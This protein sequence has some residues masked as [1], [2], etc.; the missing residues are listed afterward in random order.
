LTILNLTMANEAAHKDFI[1]ALQKDTRGAVDKLVGAV[2]NIFLGKPIVEQ[3]FTSLH[4]RATDLLLSAQD[5]SNY[6]ETDRDMISLELVEI[7]SVIDGFDKIVSGA[8]KRDPD[9][10]LT[11]IPDDIV[12]TQKGNKTFIE[13]IGG[14]K[15]VMGDNKTIPLK[16]AMELA[17][18]AEQAEARVEDG[19]EPQWLEGEAKDKQIWESISLKDKGTLRGVRRIISVVGLDPDSIATGVLGKKEYIYIDPN[20]GKEWQ[21][22]KGDRLTDVKH[23][24]LKNK[25]VILPTGEEFVPKPGDSP[26]QLY[27]GKVPDDWGEPAKEFK[28]FVTQSGGK[29]VI[30]TKTAEMND[31][32]VL[33]TA[34][35]QRVEAKVQEMVKPVLPEDA[36]LG[37]R[38]ISLKDLLIKLTGERMGLLADAYMTEINRREGWLGFEPVGDTRR[39]VIQGFDQS[40][41]MFNDALNRAGLYDKWRAISTLTEMNDR[42]QMLFDAVNRKDIQK[43]IEGGILSRLASAENI[44]TWIRDI[45]GLA[46]VLQWKE[47]GGL[48]NPRTS[49]PLAY[50]AV[51]YQPSTATALTDRLNDGKITKIVRRNGDSLS[52]PAMY[53]YQ[54]DE[55][56]I[57]VIE[58]DADGAKSMAL[59][60]VMKEKARYYG[61]DDY[62]VDLAFGFSRFMFTGLDRGYSYHKAQA[63]DDYKVIADKIG[64]AT[65][66]FEDYAHLSPEDK[67]D[68]ETLLQQISIAQTGVKS[69]FEAVLGLRDQNPQNRD[70]WYREAWGDRA[71][72]YGEPKKWFRDRISW[73]SDENIDWNQEAAR[74]DVY[75]WM[76]EFFSTLGAGMMDK[77]GKFAGRET[78]FNPKNRHHR[79]AIIKHLRTSEKAGDLLVGVGFDMDELTPQRLAELIDQIFPAGKLPKNPRGNQV[80]FLSELTRFNDIMGYEGGLNATA[81]D[82][83]LVAD[84]FKDAVRLEKV[85]ENP[86]FFDNLLSFTTDDGWTPN[87]ELLATIKGFAGKINDGSYNKFIYYQLYWYSTYLVLAENFVHLRLGKKETS[88]KDLQDK[89]LG[90]WQDQSTRDVRG[91]RPAFAFHLANEVQEEFVLEK[92]K[93]KE[94]GHVALEK[95]HDEERFWN[96]A[97]LFYQDPE[98]DPAEHEKAVKE[99]CRQRMLKLH[100]EIDKVYMELLRRKQIPLS[101]VRELIDPDGNTQMFRYAVMTEDGRLVGPGEDNGRD[102]QEYLQAYDRA[103]RGLNLQASELEHVS[104]LNDLDWASTWGDKEEKK[105]LLQDAQG[106]YKFE[107]KDV[108][109]GIM[110]NDLEI[111]QQLLTWYNQLKNLPE[112][113]WIKRDEQGHFDGRDIPQI[114]VGFAREYLDYVPKDADGNPMLDNTGQEI[115]LAVDLRADT[116]EAEAIRGFFRH[117]LY[118]NDRGE[119]NAL[120]QEQFN[121]GFQTL[122]GLMFG[123][124]VQGRGIPEDRSRGPRGIMPLRCYLYDEFYKKLLRDGDK[125]EVARG[126][127]G[128]YDNLMQERRGVG[129][130]TWAEFFEANGVG[131]LAKKESILER[132]ASLISRDKI[133][134]TSYDQFGEQIQASLGFTIRPDARNFSMKAQ[135]SQALEARI[136]AGVLNEPAATW[137]EV[138]ETLSP[139][140]LLST[141]EISSHIAENYGLKILGWRHRLAYWFGS[142]KIGQPFKGAINRWI[143]S[144]VSPNQ[145][146]VILQNKLP[147]P[148]Q[149]RRWIFKTYG[150]DIG[151][152]PDRAAVLDA[153]DQIVP[154]RWQDQ[155]PEVNTFV[156]TLGDASR[157]FS[158]LGALKSAFGQRWLDETIFT[159]PNRREAQVNIDNLYHGIVLATADKYLGVVTKDRITAQLSR[160]FFELR[161]TAGQMSMTIKEKVEMYKRLRSYIPFGQYSW[162]LLEIASRQL[163]GFARRTGDTLTD[164]MLGL[165]YSPAPGLSLITTL[166]SKAI[167]SIHGSVFD[168][169]VKTKVDATWGGLIPAGVAAYYAFGLVAFWGLTTGWATIPGAALVI[170]AYSG[171]G[172][173]G[174]WYMSKINNWMERKKWIEHHPAYVYLVERGILR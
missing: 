55:G 103:Q 4:S 14:E 20:T 22:E 13:A 48:V 117:W 170:G 168:T 73:A 114:L 43:G 151:N 173:V 6:G 12:I 41:E 2:K 84:E 9:N 93:R 102:S 23:K 104:R 28:F 166:L 3:A 116:E 106:M 53:T 140:Q 71:P 142:K 162:Q 172:W 85:L 124:D 65:D 122:I 21:P 143:N 80:N 133:F 82:F 169:F 119:Y 121:K 44:I 36:S 58:K 7:K 19:E 148:R 57:F 10:P 81:D 50:S 38:R 126:Y 29:Q 92:I 79:Q 88:V 155:N 39:M 135:V 78:P 89:L 75:R 31:R 109:Y 144:R 76:G 18:K 147:L 52:G 42:F 45:P 95:M 157:G 139:A 165:E 146:P 167:P 51:I 77:G 15:I 25:L 66:I 34:K 127:L 33:T 8:E 16:K 74:R 83:D 108:W 26:P 67:K 101:Q 131:F 35:G 69:F 171:V 134:S 1:E 113:A 97:V 150:I 138:N 161:L 49:E 112:E 87:P 94:L 149:A 132:I 70:R 123:F 129:Q 46:G 27:K 62:V 98:L 152:Q 59:V 164:T 54:P 68:F 40:H 105:S 37:T 125:P 111:Y 60:N 120:G 17:K 118:S 145:V 61:V 107:V 64:L 24:P 30:F 137:N 5:R 130:E 174:R 158:R 160:H 115:K 141:G 47:W 156:K 86:A 11:L 154:V 153:I 72:L 63:V 128:F 163:F 136:N 99:Y 90:G 96:D 32:V 100:Y 56:D 110:E 91:T 159:K